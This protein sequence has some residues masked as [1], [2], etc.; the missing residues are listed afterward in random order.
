MNQRSLLK[1]LA[2]SLGICGLLMGIEKSAFAQLQNAQEPPIYQNSEQD[3]SKGSF[4]GFDPA[5][6][7]HNANLSRSR[8]GADFAEDTQQNL[9]KAAN[10]FKRQQQLLLQNQPVEATPTTPATVPAKP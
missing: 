10:D 2:L 9:N 6:L 1:P 8:N 7:I 3:P 5:S 4:S